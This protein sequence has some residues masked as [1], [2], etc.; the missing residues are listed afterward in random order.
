MSTLQDRISA[1][2]P[3]RFAY[4]VLNSSTLLITIEAVRPGVWLVR[5]S[6]DRFGGTFVCPKAALKFVR[7]ETTTVQGALLIA[8]DGIGTVRQKSGGDAF[9]P[10][11]CEGFKPAA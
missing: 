11:A 9:T 6:D 3:Q 7:A 5:S 1:V 4:S 8:V 10:P 2:I